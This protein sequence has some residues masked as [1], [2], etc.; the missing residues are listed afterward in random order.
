V[1]PDNESWKLRVTMSLARSLR[2]TNRRDEA[3]TMLADIL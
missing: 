1:S 3:R 2:D